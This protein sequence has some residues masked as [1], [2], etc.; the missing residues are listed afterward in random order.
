MANTRLKPRWNRSK[1]FTAYI[2]N[3]NRNSTPREITGDTGIPMPLVPSNKIFANESAPTFPAPLPRKVMRQF[4]ELGG[5][6]KKNKELLVTIRRALH[7]T[8]GSEF[9]DVNIKDHDMRR[10]TL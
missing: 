4:P 7:I 3:L 6:E 8:T 1:R 5:W 2:T 9:E 10:I